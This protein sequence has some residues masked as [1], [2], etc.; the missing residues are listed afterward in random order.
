MKKVGNIN[1]VLRYLL[2]ETISKKLDEEK[3]L[4]NFFD[5]F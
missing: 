4:L 5:K 2:L 3:V 1:V